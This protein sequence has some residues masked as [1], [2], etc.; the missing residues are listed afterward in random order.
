MSDNLL[1]TWDPGLLFA[2][3]ALVTLCTTGILISSISVGLVQWRKFRTQ[4]ELRDFVQQLID[5]G[6]TI[7]EIERLT[8]TFNGGATN[9]PRIKSPAR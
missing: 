4:R 9:T 3:M 5:Q 7:E 2:L 8:A 1:S 6:Y